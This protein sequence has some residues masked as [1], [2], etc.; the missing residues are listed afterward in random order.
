MAFRSEASAFVVRHKDAIVR[1]R[2]AGQVAGSSAV[3]TC[4]DSEDVE[5]SQEIVKQLRSDAVPVP[6]SLKGKVKFLVLQDQEGMRHSYGV[7]CILDTDGARNLLS[8]IE[9]N[10][11]RTHKKPVMGKLCV[12]FAT[13][14]ECPIGKICPGV[15]V[16]Q[17]GTSCRN[18]WFDAKLRLKGLIAK[19]RPSP[20]KERPAAA[21]SGVIDIHD[22]WSMDMDNGKGHGGVD[23]C[24]HICGR[25]DEAR[26]LVADA[27]FASVSPGAESLSPMDYTSLDKWRHQC[28]SPRWSPCCT[29]EQTESTFYT[30]PVRL[31]PI[32]CP[33]AYLYPALVAGT[34]LGPSICNA[35]PH[36]HMPYATRAGSKDCNNQVELS[37]PLTECEDAHYHI[38]PTRQMSQVL[39]CCTTEVEHLR[40]RISFTRRRLQSMLSEQPAAEP[41]FPCTSMHFSAAHHDLLGNLRERPPTGCA[42]DPE[43]E[44]SHVLE[45]ELVS[46]SSIGHESPSS[47]EAFSETSVGMDFHFNIESYSRTNLLEGLRM[48]ASSPVERILW[49]DEDPEDL[50]SF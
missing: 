33:S 9:H 11:S 3:Q 23:D 38:D 32:E 2:T 34:P 7:R 18:I 37:T 48:V 8:S 1:S 15:H 30:G 36:V 4:A 17:E 31:P 14:M 21:D 25:T 12:P 40:H 44:R 20:K 10:A 24:V 5:R 49:A 43:F 50:M 28:E 22:E 19:E 45:D 46:D 27:M 26:H 6:A 41:A 47:L 42:S 29:P 39:Q 13:N 16:T 35:A